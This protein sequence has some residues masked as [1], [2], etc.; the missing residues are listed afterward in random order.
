MGYL[1]TKNER[2]N[3]I[4]KG[5]VIKNRVEIWWLATFSLNFASTYNHTQLCFNPEELKIS[6]VSLS[7]RL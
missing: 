1:P 2:K 7:V 4:I 6:E 5:I 3:S